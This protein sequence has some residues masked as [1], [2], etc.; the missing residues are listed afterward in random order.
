MEFYKILLKNEILYIKVH[1]KIA[2]KFNNWWSIHFFKVF[3]KV[4]L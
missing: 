3:L 2:A 1:S 4:I